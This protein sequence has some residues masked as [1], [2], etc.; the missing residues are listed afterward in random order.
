MPA[1]TR[2]RRRRPAR[3]RVPFPPPSPR[4]VRCVLF[5]RA[6]EV[7]KT[8]GDGLSGSAVRAAGVDL[9]E[10]EISDRS[11]HCV[12]L[13]AGGGLLQSPTHEDAGQVLAVL[14]AG[15]EV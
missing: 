6:P 9:A 4:G 11:T 2:H 15:V 12:G 3:T 1:P 7:L 14:D 8:S 5:G 10:S 13:S